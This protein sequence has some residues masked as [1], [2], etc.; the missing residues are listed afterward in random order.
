MRKK[1]FLVLFLTCTLLS[2]NAQEKRV[3]S[4]DGK[5]IVSISAESGKPIYTISYNGKTFLEKSPLGLKTNVGDFSEG[6][7]MNHDIITSNIDENY[8][9]PDIKFRKVHYEAIESVCT[10]TKGNKK[11]F[12]VVLRVSNNDVAIKYIM[13]PHG[14]NLSCIVIQE[15]TGFTL[16][17]G[18]TTFLCPQSKPIG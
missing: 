8:E 9:L 17:T 3:T 7:A 15:A 10:F 1:C 4:P 18:T 14:A 12:D 5:L 13:Y 2:I 16:P 6:M 11:A